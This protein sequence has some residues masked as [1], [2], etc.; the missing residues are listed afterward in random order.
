[1]PYRVV[2]GMANVPPPKERA[3][4]LGRGGIIW[5]C[6]A[7]EDRNLHRDLHLPLTEPRGFRFFV[8]ELN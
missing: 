5:Y 8:S 2:A 4:A 3:K 1:M 6:K 7:Y